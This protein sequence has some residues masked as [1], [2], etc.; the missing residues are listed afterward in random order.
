MVSDLMQIKLYGLYDDGAL[1]LYGHFCAHAF[2]ETMNFTMFTFIW[3]GKYVLPCK[4][5]P[6]F[7]Q[8]SNIPDY[9]DSDHFNR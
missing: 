3:V 7:I 4:T 6:S 5:P 1:K 9:A 8:L 2:S